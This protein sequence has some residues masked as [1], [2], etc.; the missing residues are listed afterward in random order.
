MKD[1]KA[2]RLQDIFQDVPRKIYRWRDGIICPACGEAKHKGVIQFQSE[3]DGLPARV[4][5]LCNVCAFFWFEETVESRDRRVR[6]M[7]GGAG[8]FVLAFSFFMCTIMGFIA[9]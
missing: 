6:L 5:K 8:V 4:S 3:S 2:P 7:V 9:R 1:V